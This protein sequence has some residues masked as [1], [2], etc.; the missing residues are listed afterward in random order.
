[1]TGYSF[2]VIVL[3][4]VLRMHTLI[5]IIIYNIISYLIIYLFITVFV[6]INLNLHQFR[7]QRLSRY[8][9]II[10]LIPNF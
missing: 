8:R 4:I 2:Q 9:D 3:C 1:M 5:Y 7:T 10:V 6:L